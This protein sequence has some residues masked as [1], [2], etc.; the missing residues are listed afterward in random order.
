MTTGVLERKTEW[1]LLV[2]RKLGDHEK[3]LSDAEKEHAVYKAVAAEQ[4]KFVMDR[5]NRIQDNIAETRNELTSDIS[6]I[7]SNINKVL[8]AIGA[9]VILA[10]VQFVV[11]GGLRLPT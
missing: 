5:F 10:F 3:R 11:S 6:K 1:Q 4:Q 7:N 9:A 2:D 8:W